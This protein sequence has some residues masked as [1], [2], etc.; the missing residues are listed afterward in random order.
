MAYN[1]ALAERVRGLLLGVPDVDEKKMFGGVTFM[2]SGQMCCG[3]L[4]DDLVVKTGPD[5]FD[6]LVARPHVR[7][8]DFTG[9]PMVGMVYVASPGVA[10]DLQLQEWVQRGV[11]FV[12]R[13]PKS[14]TRKSK[15]K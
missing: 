14:R 3:V 12:K 15:A 4:K 10:T 1:E 11:D 5:G 6:D 7:P 9:R 8:F 2:V 13:N